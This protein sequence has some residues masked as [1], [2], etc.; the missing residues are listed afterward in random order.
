VQVG[1]FSTEALARAAAGA[2]R[3]A[4]GAPGSRV[5]VQPVAQ[6]RGTLYRA[7]V[8]GLSQS[9]AQ[10]LCDRLRGRGGCAVLQPDS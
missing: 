6:G 8:A 4:A 5:V 9:A 10:Q 7:R 3:E 1:A 2:A